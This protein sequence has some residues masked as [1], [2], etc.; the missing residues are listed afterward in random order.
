MTY[1]VYMLA[2]GHYG[3]LYVGVTRDLSRRVEEHRTKATP[4]GFTTRYGVDRLVYFQ[5][6]G[7]VADAIRFEKLLK[8]W[9][10]D[11]KVRLVEET[12]P[13][14]E[15]LYLHMMTPPSGAPCSWIPD[16]RSAAS[17][18]TELKERWALKL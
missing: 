5:G 6:F 7:D 3:T 8:R 15:D 14:W 11:W 9:R 2:S 4:G 18:M 12:N 16:S 10:R 17:G 13:H 1:W